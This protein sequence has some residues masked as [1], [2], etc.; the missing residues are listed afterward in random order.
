MFMSGM[1]TITRGLLT[2]SS[3]PDMIRLFTTY[4]FYI[5]RQHKRTKLTRHYV[6]ISSFEEIKIDNMFLSVG[7]NRFICCKE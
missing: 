2:L 4:C 1:K 3:Y 5:A 6:F 7:E